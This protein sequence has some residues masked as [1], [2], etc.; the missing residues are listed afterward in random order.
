[1]HTAATTT[2]E[3]ST[4]PSG[5]FEIVLTDRVLASKTNPRTHF[6]PVY[7]SELAGSI[8][9]KG[10]IQPLVVRRHPKKPDHFEIIAGEC[11]WRGSK[12][13]G[14][15]RLPVVIREMTDDQVLEAQLEEN[16]HRKDLT[17]LE[18][19][20]GYRRLIA[21][22]PT[23]HSAESIATRIGMS[24]SYVWDRLKLND[25][26]PEAKTLLEENHITVGHAIPLARL[27]PEDQKRAIAVPRNQYGQRDSGLWRPDYSFNYDGEHQGKKGKYDGFK[28]CSVREFEKW[29]QNH[30]RFDVAHAAQA[31]PLV[32]E[33]TAAAVQEAT[34][35]PGRR[36]KVIPITHDY[37]V[38]DDARDDERT[39]GKES[40]QRA[41]GVKSK[42]CEHSVLGLV[43]AGPGQGSTLQ[44]CVARDRCRVHFAGVIK[45]KEQNT[46]LRESGQAKKAARNEQ[47]DRE[48]EDQRRK[49]EEAKIEAARKT[50][51]AA[52]ADIVAAVADT[53]KAAP[54]SK[55]IDLEARGDRAR[56]KEAGIRLFKRAPKTAEEVLRSL[57]LR[58]VTNSIN[59]DWWAPRN[60]PAQVKRELGLDV[61]PILKKHAPP[62]AAAAK[63]KNGKKR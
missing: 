4:P 60:Y 12:E 54:L 22:N 24:V 21:S 2:A 48:R 27:K 53:I 37:R 16:I 18:E 35:Q 8:A 9:E 47:R 41:D 1:M 30:V 36:R 29:I 11:R 25:L 51:R 26:L 62:P 14:V 59:N 15:A 56:F 32:F 38:A 50:W 10:L 55:L 3:P 63:P 34:A 61:E 40:W 28:P 6:D 23:K 52:K 49:A 33:T 19:A 31:Q 5:A 20:A 43:V 42:T 44:V 46:K 39:Y 7:I 17:A 58:T 57:A 45:R 13:A